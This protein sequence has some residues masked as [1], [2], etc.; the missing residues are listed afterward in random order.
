M[1]LSERSAHSLDSTEDV[2]HETQPAFE[3]DRLIHEPARLAIVVVL[4]AA[5]EVDFKFL[6]YMTNLTKGNL[7]RQ[8]EKLAEVGYIEVR[9]YYKGRVPATG[10]RLTETGRA[11]FAHYREQMMRLL[12]PPQEK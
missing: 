10:Y 4:E 5:E 9:K 6:L 8:T 11:A 2:H 1:K 3:L 12:Q 7:S